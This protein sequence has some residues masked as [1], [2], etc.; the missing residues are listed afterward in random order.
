[1]KVTKTVCR[2]WVEYKVYPNESSKALTFYVDKD[3]INSDVSTRKWIWKNK[4]KYEKIC[5]RILG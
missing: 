4:D 1:M 2:D 5:Q 3:G